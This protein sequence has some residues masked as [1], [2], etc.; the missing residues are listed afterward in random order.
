V[1]ARLELQQEGIG[2]NIKANFT[3]LA[4]CAGLPLGVIGCSGEANEEQYASIESAIDECVVATPQIVEIR[5]ET[6][7]AVAAGIKKIYHV[8]VRNT[9]SSGCGPSTITYTPDSFKFF[10]IIPQ[11]RSTSG[12]APGATTSFRV[13]AT[14]DPSLPEG[15]TELGF[16]IIN[17]PTVGASTTARGS[18]RYEIDFDNPTGCNRQTP[19]IE[20]TPASPPPVPVNTTINYTVTIR[21]VDN[22]EC[23]PDDFSLI[24]DFARFFSFTSSPTGRITI[25]PGGSGNFTVSATAGSMVTPGIHDL[26]FTVFPQRHPTTQQPRGFVRYILQ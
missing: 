16:T 22:V 1:F 14:S 2:M 18:L 10:S 6:P 19:Q 4:I 5:E 24:L 17:N 20:V 12:V 3:V 8:T 23:G 9:N 13:E 15:V 21:N 11:P 25:P 7:G 26:G